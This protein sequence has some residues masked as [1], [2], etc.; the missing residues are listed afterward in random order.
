VLLVLTFST[1]VRRLKN[2][3]LREA[4]RYGGLV[5]VHSEPYS[6][7]LRPSWVSV[8]PSSV[9]TARELFVEVRHEGF[10]VRYHRTPVARDQS[11]QDGY[12]DTYAERIRALPTRTQLVFNCGAGVVRSTFAMSVALLVRRRMLVDQG[13]PDPYG[14]VADADDADDARDGAKSPVGGDGG[15]G[16]ARRVLRQQ[17]EQARR[18]RSLLRLMHV[19]SKSA[20]PRLLSRTLCSYS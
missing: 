13:R 3:I 18:D 6:G 10:S 7:P 20:S 9:L 11:P 2:D 17:S 16:A 14:V 4:A 19:L 8:S 1:P 15:V 5:L 12:L